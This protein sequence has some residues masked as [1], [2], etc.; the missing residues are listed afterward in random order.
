M[1]FFSD[2]CCLILTTLFLSLLPLACNVSLNCKDLCAVSSKS[3]NVACSTLL[4]LPQPGA[5]RSYAHWRNTESCKHEDEAQTTAMT[6]NYNAQILVLLL[7]EKQCFFIW[8]KFSSNNL[9]NYCKSVLGGLLIMI[10]LLF[11]KKKK[12]SFFRT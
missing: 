1:H 2:C 6:G 4:I 11:S 7:R 5:L 9:L 10:M 12:K 3:L 8:L